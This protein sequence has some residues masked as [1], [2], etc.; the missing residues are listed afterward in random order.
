[1]QMPENSDIENVNM[2]QVIEKLDASLLEIQPVIEYLEKFKKFEIINED[3]DADNGEIDI[4][5]EQE[6]IRIMYITI[7]G[8]KFWSIYRYHSDGTKYEQIDII[9]FDE[10]KENEYNR[11]IKYSGHI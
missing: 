7:S 3:I 9:L 2:I 1:M 6:L 11:V 5:H 8:G 4:L 10:I